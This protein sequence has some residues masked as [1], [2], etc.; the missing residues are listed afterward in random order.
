MRTPRHHLVRDE[1]GM[2]LIF[3]GVCMAAFIG[4][5]T[6]AIDVG[7]FMSARTQAQTSAD[8]AALS[9]V[10]ALVFNNFNDRTPTGPAVQS[11]I[12]AGQK[13]KIAGG[14]PTIASA[15]VTFPLSPSGASNR[16]Q[17]DVH[18]TGANAVPTLMGSF[19]GLSTVNINATATAEASPANAMTCVKPFMIPD[20]WSETQTPPWDPSD[21]FE[22]YDNHGNLL[23]DRDAYFPARNCLTCRDNPG[24]TGYTVARDKGMQLILRA[25]TGTN[26][27][28]SFYYSWKMPGDTGGD[29]YRDNIATCNTSLMHW[30]DLIIQEPGDMSGPTIQGINALIARDPSAYWEGS[31]NGGCNCVKGSRYQGQSPRVFPIPLY[32]PAYYAEGKSNGR[33]ADFRIA[34]FLGFFADHVQGN[35]IYGYVTNVTGVVDNA[36]GEVPAGLFPMAIRLVQ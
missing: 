33:V 12:S 9:G 25:G 31:A 4:T 2:S 22:M 11:A 36:P 7:M 10:T 24:Y 18:R 32:D 3:L 6:L 28:P 26:I 17:V 21:T 29:F 1:R 5:A 14:A 35:Q 27:N 16:V 23:P 19:L 8:S 34:N 15:D 30:Y 13:N 20:K